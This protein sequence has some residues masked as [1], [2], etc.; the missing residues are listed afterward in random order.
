MQFGIRDERYK[1]IYN[2]DRA[3]NR[4][5]ASR[6]RNSKISEDQHVESF[7]Y[8]PEYEL[9]DLQE[10]PHEWVNLANS[11]AHQSTKHRLVTAMRDFQLEINDPFVRPENIET[12]IAEQKEYATKRYK[13]P[14]FRWPH[15]KMFQRMQDESAIG[16]SR[17]STTPL[18][19]LSVEH[20]KN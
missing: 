1:L 3:L 13:R 18:Q 15:L 14:D 2:P 20:P 8:P 12:F 19:Q 9:F 4:L 5:A 16:P 6:Y 10:D 11:E 7:L 17:E